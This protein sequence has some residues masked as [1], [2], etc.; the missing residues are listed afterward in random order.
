[1]SMNKYICQGSTL[2]ALPPFNTQPIA[3]LLTYI[4]ERRVRW[5]VCRASLQPF[6]WLSNPRTRGLH[7]S[8]M[9]TSGGGGG[10]GA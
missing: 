6:F 10:G 9:G 5:C 2:S 7:T 8:E 4:P 1:M 3:P